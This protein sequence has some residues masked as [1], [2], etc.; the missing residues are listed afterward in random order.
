MIGP[1]VAIGEFAFDPQGFSH[2]LLAAF[3]G[4]AA[5]GLS[6]PTTHRYQELDIPEGSS[7]HVAL[8]FQGGDP[9]IVAEQIGLGRVVLLAIAPSTSS[10]DAETG[11]PWTTLP[12][13]PVY[14]PLVREILSFALDTQRIPRA[15]LVGQPL[16]GRV[17]SVATSGTISIGRPDGESDFGQTTSGSGSQT[18]SYPRTDRCGLY[19]IGAQDNL[20]PFA[21][22][23]DTRESDLRRASPHELTADFELYDVYSS[24]SDAANPR[25]L[26]TASRLGT[27]LLL[28]LAALAGELV[29]AHRRSQTSP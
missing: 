27:I 19:H 4:Q 21:V 28:A 26:I 6:I 24:E 15:S 22:N 25:S 16:S 29:F 11:T 14:L 5:E 17:N 8:A 9:A 10:V 12:A 18:W 7:A 13:W 3:R 20:Q 1:P 2:P 23:V